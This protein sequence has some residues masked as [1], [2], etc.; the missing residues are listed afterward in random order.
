[1]IAIAEV[2]EGNTVVI[3]EYTEVISELKKR[4]RTIRQKN[5]LYLELKARWSGERIPMCDYCCKIFPKRPRKDR[6]C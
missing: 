6:Y 1:M 4:L 3:A 5:D 2:H